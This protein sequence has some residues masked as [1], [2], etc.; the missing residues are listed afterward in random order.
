[1]SSDLFGSL[2]VVRVDGLNDLGEGVSVLGVDVSEGDGRAVLQTDKSAESG[3]ALD[4]AVWD[5]HSSA[6]GGKEDDDLDWVNVVG[7]D[8][9]R[10]LLLLDGGGDSVDTDSQAGLS[11]VSGVGL[12]GSPGE[13]KNKF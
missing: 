12:A 8:D 5:A 9:E 13:E 2:V 7:D 3:L 6:E 4:D 10:S 11:G 1:M